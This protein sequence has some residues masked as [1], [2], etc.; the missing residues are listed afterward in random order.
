M[1]PPRLWTVSLVEL[2]HPARLPADRNGAFRAVG[3]PVRG[4]DRRRAHVP[5]LAEIVVEEAGAAA[6]GVV[7]AQAIVSADETA[8]QALQLAHVAE[9]GEETQEKDEAFED[10]D[11]EFGPLRDKHK[12]EN[13][14]GEHVDHARQKQGRVS[15]QSVLEQRQCGTNAIGDQ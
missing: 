1:S 13:R 3:L 10:G 14:R 11:L 9:K 8:T 12:A 4:H 15:E 6:M 7:G 5:A 2:E